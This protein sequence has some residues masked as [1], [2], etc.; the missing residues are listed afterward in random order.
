MNKS[1]LPGASEFKNNMLKENECYSIAKPHLGRVW[2]SITTGY[3]THA[4][5]PLRLS[6]EIG[7]RASAA[8]NLMFAELIANF[9]GV[10]GVRPVTD[11]KN[12]LRFICIE[13]TVLLWLKKVTLGRTTT[14]YPTDLALDRLDGQMTISGLP[15]ASIITLGYLPNAEESSIER[16]SFSPPFRTK[17]PQWYFDL[18]PIG[19]VMQMGQREQISS[20]AKFVVVRGNSQE[21]LEL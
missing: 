13:D 17:K 7:T 8:N 19:N 12:H 5:D 9:D 4:A 3:A 2:E 1:F 15:E 11:V 21:A 10:S 20:R 6:Y 18:V 14:N 16:I